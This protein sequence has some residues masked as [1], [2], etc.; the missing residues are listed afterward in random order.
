MTRE[1][2]HILCI[3][4]E[5]DILDVAQ[6]CLETVGGYTA[7]CCNSAGEALQ[8]VA[9]IKPDIILLDVMMPQM[10]GPDAFA[11]LQAIPEIRDVPVVLMTARIQ[12]SEVKAYM[13][14]GVAAVIAKPFDA[15]TLAGDVRAIWEARHAT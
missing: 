6:M 9:Q 7:T 11:A 15:M 2:R 14:L 13:K 4:D 12:P 8:R 3:D 10:N 5:R 1:L